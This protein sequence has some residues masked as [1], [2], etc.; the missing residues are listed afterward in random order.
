MEP[1]CGCRCK[2]PGFEQP[3][4]RGDLEAR[5]LPGQENPRCRERVEDEVAGRG[6]EGESDEEESR[7]GATRGRLGEQEAESEREGADEHDE[8]EMRRVVLPD[9]IEA[10]L[11]EQN[12][13]ADEREDAERTPARQ[14]AHT[15][16]S[17]ARRYSSPPKS[18]RWC[19]G[20]ARSSISSPVRTYATG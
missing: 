9:E 12:G 3:D 19:V 2:E 4:R 15:R 5:V 6:E 14:P 13:E 7:I 11:G 20:S 8:P 16:V 18:F 10:R 17:S 1:D